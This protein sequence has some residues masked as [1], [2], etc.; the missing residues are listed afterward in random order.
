MLYP[1]I[2]RMLKPGLY[3][4]TDGDCAKATA[5]LYF[6]GSLSRKLLALV[7]RVAAADVSV[8]LTGPTGAGKVGSLSPRAT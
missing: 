2:I 7:E 1:R 3:C 4:S 5:N 8:L 6:C